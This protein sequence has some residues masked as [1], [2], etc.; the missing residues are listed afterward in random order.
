M[1]NDKYYAKE[2]NYGVGVKQKGL[3]EQSNPSYE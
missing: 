3:I 1:K 2:V